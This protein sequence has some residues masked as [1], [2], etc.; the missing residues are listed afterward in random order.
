VFHALLD[1]NSFQAMWHDV[2]IPLGSA[3][4]P[5]DEL[6]PVVDF[7]NCVGFAV[8][9]GGTWN[10][11]GYTLRSIENIGGEW[12]ARLDQ[13]TYQSRMEGDHVQPY[14]IFVLTRVP[15]ATIVVEENVADL[16]GAPPQWKERGR[17]TIPAK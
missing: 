3:R 6:R 2:V 8:T 15:G 12:H 9:A 17:V 7:A 14:G 4:R 16:I 10:S 13:I 11:R 1:E 5:T